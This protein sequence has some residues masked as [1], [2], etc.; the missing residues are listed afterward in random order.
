VDNAKSP[1][2][3]LALVDIMRRLGREEGL[4]AAFQEHDINILI[5]QADGHGLSMYAAAAG[6]PVASLP[7]GYLDVN[8]RPFGL[9][10]VAPAHQE[11]LLVQLM[12]AWEATFPARRPPPMPFGT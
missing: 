8:G 5:D 7:L 1:E 4:D 11:Q 10:A 6:Y 3:V 2:E 12:S 9:A